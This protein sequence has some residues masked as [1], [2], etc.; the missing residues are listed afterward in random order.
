M[1]INILIRTSYRPEAF[2]RCWESVRSQPT[3]PSDEIYMFVG[4]DNPASLSYLS[5]LVNVR[6]IDLTR[7]ERVGKFFYNG[8]LNRMIH[9]PYIKTGGHILFLDDDDELAPNFLHNAKKFIKPGY[10]YIF[11]FVRP[12]GFQKPTPNMMAAQRISQGYIGLPCLL[13][14]TDHRRYVHFNQSELAD[15]DAI[16]ILSFQTNLIWV[17]LP[18]VHANVRGFGANEEKH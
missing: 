16:S 3:D 8:Y 6:L 1:I 15:Y 13:L 14:S 11:P 4:Y 10:S 18:I 12:N 17:N 5:N 7:E 9:D 2:A